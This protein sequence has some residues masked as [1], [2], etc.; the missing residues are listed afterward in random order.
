[1]KEFNS[2][3]IY[4]VATV[5]ADSFKDDPL[6]KEVFK[7]VEG[8]D[9]LLYSHSL[10]H[11][12]HAVKNKSIYLLDKNPNAFLI[13]IDSKKES[14]LGD[15]LLNL[16]ILFKTI[17]LLKLDGIKSIIANNKRISNVLNLN[18]HKE[19]ISKRYYKVKIIAI[20]KELRGTGA[21][22]RL[23]S[24]VISFCDK[25]NIPMVLETHN[26]L[27][28]GLYSHFGFQL[29]KTLESKNTTIR[30]YCMLRQPIKKYTEK[31]SKL[32]GDRLWE[33]N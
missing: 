16:K 32:K 2:E 19:F 9:K 15:L 24:P 27:N 28:V 22:R 21:F 17:M 6:N 29:V 30:Q 4:R 18:W 3:T 26:N 23:I 7:D 5:M 20:D 31:D 13:G 25:E 8:K 33:M 14:K 10:I 1:M 11:T 12:I